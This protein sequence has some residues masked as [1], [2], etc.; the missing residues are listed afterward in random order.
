[1]ATDRSSQTLQAAG[2]PAWLTGGFRSVARGVDADVELAPSV[3]IESR[4][5]CDETWCFSHLT[6]RRKEF[7]FRT[8]LDERD[9]APRTVEEGGRALPVRSHRQIGADEEDEARLAIADGH[10]LRRRAADGLD[11]LRQARRQLQR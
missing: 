8:R 9:A 6:R 2:R 3:D 5:P 11:R 7:L 1:S 4:H 10:D